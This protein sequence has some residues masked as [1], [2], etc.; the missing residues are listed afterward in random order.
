MS[1]H[2]GRRSLYQIWSALAS[3]Q[4]FVYSAVTTSCVKRVDRLQRLYSLWARF[5]HLTKCA[6]VEKGR[7]KRKIVLSYRLRKLGLHAGLPLWE[8]KGE[9]QLRGRAMFWAHFGCMGG[10]AECAMPRYWDSHSWRYS[11][12][13]H[14]S[15]LCL[16]ALFLCQV[17][18][19][20]ILLRACGGLVA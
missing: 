11:G 2:K 6:G 13:L 19:A 18:A 7:N 17:T 3:L 4:R 12:I 20:G 5:P 1:V 9:H 16:S 14:P 15:C 10:R 8:E